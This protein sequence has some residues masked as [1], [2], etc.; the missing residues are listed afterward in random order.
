VEE[1][2]LRAALLRQVFDAAVTVIGGT[3]FVGLSGRQMRER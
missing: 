1:R 2:A 3:P